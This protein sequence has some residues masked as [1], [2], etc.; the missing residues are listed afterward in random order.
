MGRGLRAAFPAGALL[1]LVASCGETRG[2]LVTSADAGGVI[3]QPT[4]TPAPPT[5]QVQLT[6]ALDTSFD[7]SIYDVDLFDT[8]RA[9]IDGLHAAGRRVIC[10]VS[11]GTLESWRPDAPSFPAAAAGQAL[12]GFANEQWLDT[13]DATVRALMVARL[14]RARAQTCDGVDLSNVSPEGAATGFPFTH[15]DL[16]G[17]ARFLSAAAHQRGLGAGLGG[18]GDIAAESVAQ[19]EWAMTDGCV[20]AG[21]CAAFAPF[22][23]AHKVLFGVEFGAATDVP[24]ICPLAQQAGLDALIKHPAMDAF[25]VPCP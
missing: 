14:E 4:T 23:A 20:V 17:Y 18:G 25:T 8:P 16:L 13:R 19:F 12:A 11:V 7:V 21:S 15:A 10:Y 1:S 6:G 22:L 3:W 5:W 2:T 24:T 9:Q